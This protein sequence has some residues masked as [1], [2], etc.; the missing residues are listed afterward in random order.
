MKNVFAL[1]LCAFVFSACGNPGQGS[2]GNSFSD[3]QISGLLPA[4]SQ[5]TTNTIPGF[6]WDSVTYADYY[7]L[8]IAGSSDALETADKI[9]CSSNSYTPSNSLSINSNHYW[10]VRAVKPEGETTQWSDTFILS[11]ESF[12]PMVNLTGGQFSMGNSWDTEDKFT[13]SE[14]YVHDV[15]VS[16]FSI[17]ETEI[18]WAQW[19][20][21]YDWAIE[22]GYSFANPG[23]AGNSGISEGDTEDEPVV[24]INWRDAMTWC[25]AA[26][27]YQNLPPAY[28]YDSSVI[29]DSRDSNETA[30]DNTEFNLSSKG[31]R[32]PTE[33]EWEYA[34]RGG[35]NDTDD[36]PYAGSST[37]ND[38]AWYLDNSS[39][40]TQPV[41]AKQPNELG[42]YDMSGNVWE[43]CW[44]WF[45][46]DYYEISDL[47]DP[48]GP[49]AGTYRIFRG[50]C[51]KGYAVTCHISSRSR[52]NPYRIY[53]AVGFRPVLSSE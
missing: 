18:T 9:T 17:S 27:E 8:Q 4:S 53:D 21:V 7:E 2:S 52:T 15:I 19:K 3:I 14:L 43:W 39:D 1:L 29:R 42:L 51:W 49:S 48:T 22:N 20:E 10:R 5:T 37:L 26:S 11:I 35:N 44:D 24:N 25:N 30:C 45:E 33:A 41:G 40:D 50:G 28:L 47:N 34:A 13:A 31:Y 12:I 38:V 36:S 32:L 23:Q 6:S 46:E 16:D